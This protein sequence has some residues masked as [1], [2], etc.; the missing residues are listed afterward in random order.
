M[1]H[2]TGPGDFVVK[3]EVQ[4]TPLDWKMA[5]TLKQ[6][7]SEAGNENTEIFSFLRNVCTW[8]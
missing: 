4:G 7:H 8:C 5:Y 3:H 1:T 6:L 2:V